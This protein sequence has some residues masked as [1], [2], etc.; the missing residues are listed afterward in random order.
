MFS[1]SD[2]GFGNNFTYLRSVLLIFVLISLYISLCYYAVKSGV[3]DYYNVFKIIDYPKFDKAE[4]EMVKKSTECHRL[5][6]AEKGLMLF[7]DI[8]KFKPVQDK[9]IFFIDTSCSMNGSRLT[10]NSR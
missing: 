1:S 8:M 3:Y 10:F 7:D 2:N 5:K 6:E 4:L 9:T